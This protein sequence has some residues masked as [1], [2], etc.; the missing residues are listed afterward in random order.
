MEYLGV[1]VCHMD[2]VGQACGVGGQTLATTQL[3]A[4][5]TTSHP[6]W[7]AYLNPPTSPTTKHGNPK[8]GME[9]LKLA[10]KP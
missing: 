8:G 4:H 7:L 3:H 6:I 10:W 2:V 5:P 1:V 9:T